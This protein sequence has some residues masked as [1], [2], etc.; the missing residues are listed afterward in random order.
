MTVTSCKKKKEKEII[1]ENEK[2]I[3]EI[4]K[5]NEK[6]IEEIIKEKDIEIRGLKKELEIKDAIYKDEHKII[7]TIALQPRKTN[8]TNIIGNLNLNDTD[9]IKGI[10]E[11]KFTTDDILDGQKGLANFAVKNILKDENENLLYVCADSA[12]KMFK[13]KDTNGSIVKDVNT[14]KL[15]DAFVLCDISSITNIKSQEFWTNEDGTQ[16]FTKYNAIS[17]RFF[18]TTRN[19][20]RDIVTLYFL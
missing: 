15:T 13:F 12:R 7:E 20:F 6:K 11:R 14:Q 16:D 8:N 3:E 9:K 1:K 18:K 5:E 4:I 2:K 10:I 19:S 17:L